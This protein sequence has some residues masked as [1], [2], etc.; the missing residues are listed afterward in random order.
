MLRQVADTVRANSRSTDIIARYGGEEIVML[1]PDTSDDFAVESAERIRR[2]ID[3]D[4]FHLSRDIANV[5]VSI[6]VATTCENHDFEELFVEADSALYR[7]KAFGRNKV[8]PFRALL[9]AAA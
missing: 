9:P 3:A 8:I 6:G 7:A 2:A 4:V 5:T 1:M